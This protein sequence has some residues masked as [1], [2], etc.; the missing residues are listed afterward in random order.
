[1][2]HKADIHSDDYYTILGVAKDASDAELAKAYKKLALKH[3]PDKNPDRK[4][5]AEEEFKKL[6]EAYDVLHSPEKRKIYDQCGKAGLNGENPQ[7]DE[8]DFPFSTASG[9]RQA[10][11]SRDEADIIF[12]AF[13]G[14]ES[15]FASMFG[16]VFQTAGTDGGVN[17]FQHFASATNRADGMYFGSA[18]PRAASTPGCQAKAGHRPNMRSRRAQSRPHKRAKLHVVPNGAPVIIQGLS[19]SPQH[20]GKIGH[21]VNWDGIKARY[22]VQLRLGDQSVW[23]G[24]DKLWLRPQNITQLCLVEVTGLTSNSDINGTSGNI[25]N[26]DKTKHRYLVTVTVSDSEVVAIRPANCILSHGTNVVIDGLSKLERNGQRA[27]IVSIDRIA[28]RYTV[29]CE[30]GKQLKIK[31]ENVLC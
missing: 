30:D 31:Y 9:T 15:P 19:R 17:G 4:E 12:Q 10:K 26:F 21:V 6:T 25:V 20:N 13:F 8:G 7:A 22:E 5:E 2:S 3:H 16:S 1:M 11:M 27:Q 23:V 28:A 18:F 29:E 24:D 14:Q